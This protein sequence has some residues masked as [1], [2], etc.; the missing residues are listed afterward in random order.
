MYAEAAAAKPQPIPAHLRRIADGAPGAEAAA[1]RHAWQALADAGHLLSAKQLA[2]F[3]ARG[4]LSFPALIDQAFNREFIDW[5]AGGGSTGEGYVGED[6]RTAWPAGSLIPRL[7]AMPQVAGIIASLVGPSPRFD[8]VALHRV[9]A[10]RLQAQSWHAD[11]TIDPR[12]D[13]FDLQ[14]MYFPHD[15]PVEMGGTM[16]LPGSH[17][18]MVHETSIARYQHFVGQQP[19]VCPAGTIHVLHHG[20]WHRAR[21][22]ATD[23][24]RLMFKIR[25]NP[26]WKQERLYAPGEH[27]SP[28]INGILTRTEPWMGVDSR[29]EILNRIRLW[30]H[31]TG[32]PQFDA[33]MWLGRIESRPQVR[34]HSASVPG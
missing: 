24:E 3:V 12:E 10:G 9:P 14:L 33:S 15:L 5:V 1:A 22:N 31:L 2:E 18:R 19:T 30:R 13:A 8:H 34:I 6:L 4:V 7:L 32:D 16:L 25:L 21:G 29:L 11:A 28:E 23:R 20:I 17:L 26:R 27:R